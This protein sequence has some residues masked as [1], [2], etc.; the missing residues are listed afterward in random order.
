MQN[1]EQP[2]GARHERLCSARASLLLT[3]VP[4]RL[5]FGMTLWM[6]AVVSGGCGDGEESG[7]TG[8]VAMRGVIEGFYG[9]LYTFDARLDLLRFL[10]RAGLNTYVYAPKLDPYHRSRWRD[11][12]PAEWM[13]HFS[14]LVRAAHDVGVRFV[15]ALSPG[16][17]FDA[18]GNDQA[19]VEQ[20]LGALFDVG[21]RSFCL[22]FD[23]LVPSSQAADPQVQVQII[24][25]SFA[26][27]QAR[28]SRTQLC[29]IS[30]LYTGTAAQ[31]RAG[32]T[33][34]D[35][36]FA[37][38]SSAV[39]AAYAA[40]PPEVAILWT[41]P[42]VFASPLTVQDTV[43]FRDLVGRPLVIWDNY[44]VNDALLT[45]ELF[46]APY[47][48]REPGITQ[49]ADGV[50]LNPMLQP[51]ASKI[52]LW[53][54]GRFFADGEA[55]DPE[56]A[57]QEAFTEVAGSASGG[58]V[59]A[60]LAEQFRSHPL[61]GNQAESPELAERAT[62]FFATRSAQSEEM[63]RD[64]FR[65]FA[66]MADDLERE[67]PNVRLVAELHEPAHKLALLG[68]AGLV[69]LDL[70]DQSAR[71]E[72]VDTSAL[73]ALLD[74]ADALPWLVGANT[75]ILPGLDQL[76]AGRPAVHADVFGDFFT[77]LS[78]EL[79]SER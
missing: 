29:F 46:L 79:D 63:L 52:A 48:E 43:A 28:D 3:A 22:L 40:L 73:Q 21:V 39:Y 31:V 8:T 18:S 54:A 41:G 12:Y 65:S 68:E 49:V 1:A 50:L 17:G 6:L 74:A 36:N 5:A 59:V 9:P 61:I 69:G 37:I 42:H 56:A 66:T 77:H 58:A 16:S 26:F 55:Y 34:F 72:P 25:D 76:L 20:K 62:A 13:N 15:F 7:A 60:R 32:R 71:G 14:A 30:H 10:P 75:P 11:P 44:P 45:Q 47:R 33:P 78:A 67:V 38:K 53:T 27:L 2:V 70:L 24:A 4:W 64:L 57:L 35:G 23:D 51:E 19:T